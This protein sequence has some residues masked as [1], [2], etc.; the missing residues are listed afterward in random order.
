MDLQRSS[1]VKVALCL[2]LCVTSM[3]AKD[4]T[5]TTAG[6]YSDNVTAPVTTNDENVDTEDPFPLQGSV[7]H[8]VSLYLVPILLFSGTAGNI[9]SFII[10]S[11]PAFRKSITSFLFR[12]L[13][14]ADTVALNYGL[15]NNWLGY[16]H[17]KS[18]FTET[19][20]Y[21]KVT[22]Y[23]KYVFADFPVWVLVLISIE[24][25]VGVMVPHRARLIITKPRLL[26][27]ILLIFLFLVVYNIPMM[28]VTSSKTYSTDGKDMYHCYYD[29]RLAYL[30]MS[31]IP[32]MDL[33]IYS[34]LPLLMMMISN[35][36]IIFLV[37]KRR[38]LLESRRSKSADANALTATLLTVC[39]VF[40]LL[41]LPHAIYA[42]SANHLHESHENKID[43]ITWRLLAG[44]LRYVNN[45]INFF[46]YCLSGRPFR[47]ELRRLFCRQKAGLYRDISSNSTRMSVISKTSFSL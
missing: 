34:L 19:E 2:W 31:V 28:M 10:Y 8:V 44:F 35:S 6:H 14:I 18:L 11:Q 36:I 3:H 33:T 20:A 1:Q 15:W 13:A 41:T 16:M 43:F 5:V 22:I 4:V 7:R 25:V 38:K 12:I 9:L 26:L 46:L 29:M 23:L 45:A 24:R 42:I 37:M 17:G 40:M 21:C 47:K 30:A 39:F 32:W 27:A